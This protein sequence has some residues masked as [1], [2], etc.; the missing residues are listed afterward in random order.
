M[1]TIVS[2]AALPTAER[3]RNPASPGHSWLSHLD[4]LL[5][6][7]A[8]LIGRIERGEDLAGI[9]RAMLIAIAVSAAVFGA[10]IGFYRGGV[11]VLY[12][13]LKLPMV[14]LLTAAL[15]A[16][17]LSALRSALQ[18][19]THITADFSIILSSLALGSTLL[20]ATAPVVLLAVIFDAGYH[21]LA[22]L[23]VLCCLAAGLGGLLFFLRALYRRPGPARGLI[24]MVLLG[25]FCLVGSQMTWTW[26]PF[27]VRPKAV[28]VVF[29]RA[30]EGSLFDS[31]SLSVDSA[32]GVYYDQRPGEV[33]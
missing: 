20:A 22:L 26:R 1:S 21:G 5:R 12:A 6:Q 33:W 23:V 25:T 7:R 10:S 29:L 4:R 14:I 19:R 2:T 27:L 11:Q 17:A 9:G 8:D 30:L 13:A 28:D 3:T 16:P 18:G 31:V 32:R 15:C 24:A